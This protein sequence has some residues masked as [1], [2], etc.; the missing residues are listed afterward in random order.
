MKMKK[1]RQ[2]IKKNCASS[3][4]LTV[5]TIGIEIATG[6]LFIISRILGTLLGGGG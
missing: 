1:I 5:P 6:M 3:T 4:P 2:V